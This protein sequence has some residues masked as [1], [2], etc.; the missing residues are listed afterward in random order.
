MIL[1]SKQLKRVEISALGLFLIAPCSFFP[2]L[3]KICQKIR[4]NYTAQDF[5]PGSLRETEMSARFK[6]SHNDYIS[7]KVLHRSLAIDLPLWGRLTDP[8][9]GAFLLHKQW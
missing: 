6:K 8:G 1:Y 5:S 3:L 4:Q 9:A 7:H 2:C